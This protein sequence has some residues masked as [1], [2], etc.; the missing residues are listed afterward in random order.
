[1]F[2]MIRDG[3]ARSLSGGTVVDYQE[4]PGPVALDLPEMDWR[5]PPEGVPRGRG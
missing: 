1:M 4:L 5:I 3:W 2:G